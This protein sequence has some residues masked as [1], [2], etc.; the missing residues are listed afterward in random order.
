MCD[1]M[2]LPLLLPVDALL[3]LQ[4]INAAEASACATDHVL[5]EN[6]PVG[7]GSQLTEILHS[8]M[9]VTT[10]SRHDGHQHNMHC[11]RML[12]ETIADQRNLI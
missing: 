11:G 10:T 4:H 8:S 2:I 7:Q 12:H 5:A 6:L 1:G 3:I 9:S